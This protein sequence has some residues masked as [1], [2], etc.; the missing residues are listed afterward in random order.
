MF[1]LDDRLI[2]EQR[3]REI[4]KRLQKMQSGNGVLGVQ[5]R[6][7]WSGSL[8][9]ARNRVSLA[10]DRRDME[11]RITR[12][13]EIGFGA[14]LTNQTDDESLTSAI[15]AAERLMLGG[16][17]GPQL[18]HDGIKWIPPLLPFP[19]TPIWSETTYNVT[20]K[21]R[22]ALAQPLTVGAE[23]QGLLSAGFLQMYVLEQQAYGASVSLRRDLAKQ[24]VP[25]SSSYGDGANRDA[26][27]EGY[28]RYTEAQC[29]M[30]VR[31]PQG[32][33]S[34]WAGLSSY[35]WSAIDAE[36]LA[37]RALDKC[38]KSLNPVA[39][40]PGR[41]TVILEPQAVAQLVEPLVSALQSRVIHEDLRRQGV[42]SLGVDQ[43]IGIRRTKLGLQ[44]IDKRISISHDPMDPE[45][46]VLPKLGL[47]PITWIDHGTLTT[48]G[49]DRG[50]SVDDYSLAQLNDNLPALSRRSFRMT[51]G[52]TKIDEMVATTERGL[53]VTRFS[54]IAGIPGGGLSLLHTGLTRDGLW[55]IEGGVITRAVKNMRFTDSPLFLL[56]QV[57]LLGVPVPVFRPGK[58]DL[59]PAV[60]PPVKA[61]DFAFTATIDAV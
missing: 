42:F 31:H 6:A 11:I 24:P 10:S 35:D 17:S 5:V 28:T 29:S 37:T 40:E 20:A 33:G 44:V 15:R 27:E 49:Y 12:H 41:Y 9:W 23:E 46:G 30:T 51:G 21:Q 1:N 45:L 36:V 18:T 32:L 60:V 13:N 25:D 4:Y 50:R 59:R 57:D 22:A 58:Y 53:L 3:A 47:T 16:N 2:T 56:N 39:I 38:V 14:I 34:G 26:R 43:A 54:N 48:L 61:D 7:W 19:E 8:R 55:L 52:T